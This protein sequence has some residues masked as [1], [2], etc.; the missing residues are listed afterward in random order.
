MKKLFP[1]FALFMFSF[2]LL[3]C[4]KTQIDEELQTQRETQE[5]LTDA[6]DKALQKEDPEFQQ[7]YMQA[8]ADATEE[9][10]IDEDMALIDELEASNDKKKAGKAKGSCNAIEESSTCLE[11]YGS[12]WN[13]SGMK[14]Q[15][16]GSGVY[17]QAPCPGDM[18]GGCNTGIGTPADMVAWMYLRG[19][20]EIEPEAIKFAK[21][22]CDA[23]LASAWIEK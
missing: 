18:A 11:F 23:T 13:E 5:L 8:L 21:M 17:S 14:L 1:I 3:G 9:A 16:E 7:D 10:R 4:D 22:S 15:C 2:I 12:F 6:E 19:G 20:G